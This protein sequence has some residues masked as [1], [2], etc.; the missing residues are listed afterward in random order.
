MCAQDK[1]LRECIEFYLEQNT[2]DICVECGNRILYQKGVTT[3]V[4]PEG[5]TLWKECLGCGHKIY[6]VDGEASTE[7]VRETNN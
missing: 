4:G 5:Y 2:N 7:L 6:V 1:H 3:A